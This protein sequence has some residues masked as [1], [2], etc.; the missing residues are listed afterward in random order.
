MTLCEFAQ[1]ERHKYQSPNVHISI[2]QQMPDSL[3]VTT[4]NAA[5][6]PLFYY[7]QAS[8]NWTTGV[9]VIITITEGLSL[10]TNY[11]YSDFPR[12]SQY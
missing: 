1:I 6:T 5:K 4:W 9:R 12:K 10:H 2:M 7:H 8:L 3:T 11:L